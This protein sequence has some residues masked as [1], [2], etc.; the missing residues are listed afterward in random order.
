MIR[1]RQTRTDAML[2]LLSLT[3]RALVA[4]LL[5]TYLIRHLLL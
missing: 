1:I 2:T 4:A 5:L 3:G